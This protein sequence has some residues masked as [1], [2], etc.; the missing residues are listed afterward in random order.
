MMDYSELVKQLRYCANCDPICDMTEVCQ[1][2]DQ[3]DEEYGDYRCVERMME[4]AADAIEQL[5]IE[6]LHADCV[7]GEMGDKLSRL[8]RK[9]CGWCGVC[10]E[11]KQNVWDCEIVFPESQVP[12]VSNEPPTDPCA[13]C[14]HYP[15]S[16]TDGKPCCACDPA[17]PLTNCHEAKEETE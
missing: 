4:N 7:I 3:R 13:D 8:E 11:D 12:E 1:F 5:R 15:P 9:L 2:Y 6:Q 16:S 17:N 10:P 14:V